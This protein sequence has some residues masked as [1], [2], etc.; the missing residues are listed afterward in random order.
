M[1][2]RTVICAT[3]AGKGRALLTL[4][5]AAVGEV[6]FISDISQQPD[7][8]GTQEQLTGVGL[9]IGLGGSLCGGEESILVRWQTSGLTLL[10]K[11]QHHM[12][13]FYVLWPARTFRFFYAKSPWLLPNLH[14]TNG[15][16]TAL[17]P[18]AYVRWRQL[19]KVWGKV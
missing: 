16:A 4:Q 2:A 5:P 12:F 8:T 6:G 19:K 18:V 1:E 11:C 17:V 3:V 7:G 15:L 9:G 10:K 14:G 13:F